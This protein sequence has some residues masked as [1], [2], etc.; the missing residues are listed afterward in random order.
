MIYINRFF[1]SLFFLFL[2]SLVSNIFV[3]A[4]AHDNDFSAEHQE[5]D[6]IETSY[7]IGI[8]IEQNV[9]TVLLDFLSQWLGVAYK[10]G[11]ASKSGTDCSGFVNN[12]YTFVYN[13]KLPR[14]SIDIFQKTQI[15]PKDELTSGDLVFFKTLGSKVV[16]HVG[17]Y[18]WNGY[19]AHA[20]SKRGVVISQ[21]GEGYYQKTYA[22][23]GYYR[24]DL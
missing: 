19:F 18:L 22:G 9:D 4:Q 21:L 11:G 16:N 2:F 13:R 7:D 14:R 3:A 10:Y 5:A 20:S 12:C 23:G 15:L 1:K 17:V 6:A 24:P 8:E